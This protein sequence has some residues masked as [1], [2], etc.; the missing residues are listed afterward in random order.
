[1]MRRTSNSFKVVVPAYNSAHWLPRTLSSIERQ[2][3]RH[4][5]VCIVDDD[6]SDPAQRDIIKSYCD[7]L[8]WKAIMNTKRKGALANIVTGIRELCASDDDIIVLL[9]GDDWL[10]D[11]RV[12][13]LLN[14]Y[15]LRKDIH[16]SYGQL[17]C[18]SNGI[19]R[20]SGPVSKENIEGRQYRALEWK[21]SHLRTFRYFLW[22]R[23]R[24]E[25]LR[26]ESGSYFEV[27]WDMAIMFPLLEMAGKHIQ[28]IP[29]VLYVYNDN[30]PLCD[31]AIRHSEQLAA[32]K[33]IRQKP[34]YS[35]ACEGAAADCALPFATRFRFSQIKWILNVRI[36]LMDVSRLILRKTRRLEAK[37]N[38]IEV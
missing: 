26:D 2:T 23:I 19:H 7:R 25:D 1:M 16:V 4:Y 20:F 24:D 3:Y 31:A 10:F 9:D 8:G 18:A 6:S 21:F 35:C 17:V 30:N 11:R 32:E 15:Y 29:D 5:E 13:E 27:S 22:K 14:I 34:P 36:L 33:R 38:A 28:F 12:F 37:I